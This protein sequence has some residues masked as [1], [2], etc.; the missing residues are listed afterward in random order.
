MPIWQHC[1]QTLLDFNGGTSCVQVYVNQHDFFI[2]KIRE[3]VD[4]SDN[5]Y[6]SFLYFLHPSLSF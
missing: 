1:A 2:N 5:L 3:H 4:H 6:V